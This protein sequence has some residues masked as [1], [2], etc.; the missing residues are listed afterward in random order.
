[1]GETRS[2]L[3]LIISPSSGRYKG[4]K[5]APVEELNFLNNEVARLQMLN[6]W[7]RAHTDKHKF[8]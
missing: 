5:Q 7:A 1:M 8:Y 3:R 6:R 4:A 2:I